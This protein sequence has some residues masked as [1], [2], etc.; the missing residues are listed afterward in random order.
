LFLASLCD[1][2]PLKMLDVRTH[3]RRA[4]P[5]G[6]PRTKEPEKRLSDFC[7]LAE[8]PF[9]VGRLPPQKI[10]NVTASPS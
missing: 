1:F 10:M 3:R 9:D 5:P 2:E 8:R 7:E 6:G 4:L